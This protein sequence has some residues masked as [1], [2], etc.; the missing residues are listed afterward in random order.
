VLRTL[1]R[2]RVGVIHSC[3]LVAA[4]L[5]IRIMLIRVVSRQRSLLLAILD[6]VLLGIRHYGCVVIWALVRER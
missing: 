2:G 5:R 4:I 6:G 1:G 3:A